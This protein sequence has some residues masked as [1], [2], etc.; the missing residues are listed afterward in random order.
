MTLELAGSQAEH[1]GSFAV[2]AVVSRV[3][4]MGITRSVVSP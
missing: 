3:V 1:A 2:N 4:R